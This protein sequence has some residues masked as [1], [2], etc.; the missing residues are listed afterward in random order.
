[1]TMVPNAGSSQTRSLRSRFPL[2]TLAGLAALAASL[3]S[4]RVYIPGAIIP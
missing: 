4:S 2:A 1:M 3:A